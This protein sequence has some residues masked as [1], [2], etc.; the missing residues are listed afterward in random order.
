VVHAHCLSIVLLARPGSIECAWSHHHHHHCQILYLNLHYSLHCSLSVNTSSIYC[1]PQCARPSKL[2][3][4]RSFH[5]HKCL[6]SE[7]FLFN[8]QSNKGSCPPHHKSLWISSCHCSLT[9]SSLI[10]DTITYLIVADFAQGLNHAPLIP[11]G[12][13][14]FLWNPVESGGIKIGPEPSQNDI[15]GDKYSSGMMLFLIGSQNGPWN[16]QKGMHQERN[17]QN[18]HYLLIINISKQFYYSKQL[19]MAKSSIG[20]RQHSIW[21][22]KQTTTL[23][24][25]PPPPSLTMPLKHHHR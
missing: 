12:F 21:C 8:L 17:D 18:T 7:T 20:K 3:I 25:T 23:A 10:D 11:A 16:G 5:A 14:S 24:F 13:Q 15:L 2:T 22:H 6:T 1:R 4:V 9:T 19:A